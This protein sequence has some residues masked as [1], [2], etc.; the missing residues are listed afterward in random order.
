MEFEGRIT[1]VLP[2]RTGTRQD[3][4]TWIDLSLVFAYFENGEQR[5]EDSA[6]V[7]TFDANI[8][9][10]IAPYI[11]RGQDGKTV[12]ENGVSKLNV[13]YIPCR[14]GFSL[15]VKNAQK[16]DGSGPLRIQEVRCY[17]LEVTTGAAT[18]QQQT[19]QLI[20][21]PFS[22]QTEENDDLPF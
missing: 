19:Q 9:A 17:R 12:I 20:Q 11:V 22:P 8:M 5:F 4:S 21:P 14:C 7:S 10:K 3:G 2:A 18:K 16:K 1:A 15:K 13:P 6:I